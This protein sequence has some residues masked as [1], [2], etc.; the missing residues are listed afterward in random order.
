MTLILIQPALP[1]YRVNFFRRL[2]AHYGEDMRVHYSPIDMGALTASRARDLWEHPIGPIR[3]PIRGLEW[4]VGALSVPITRGDTVVVSGA[5]RTLS[6][7][8]LLAR[9]RMIGAH[10]IWWGQYW[11]ATTQPHRLYLRMKLSRLAD[12]LLFYT[13]AEVARYH[14]DGWVHPGPVGA[15]NNGIDLTEVRRLRRPYNPSVRGQ[16]LLFVGRLTAKAQL[17]LAINALAEPTLNSTYLHV[18]GEGAEEHVL[19]AQA[20]VLGVANRIIWYGGT[21]NEALI[22]EVANRCAAFVYPGQVGL[23]LIH[24]MGYGLPCIVHDQPTRHMP[25]IAA[26]ENGATGLTFVE[27]DVAALARSVRQL[28]D[29]KEA[30]V[31]MSAGCRA[32]TEADYT[33]ETMTARFL[34]FA[35]RLTGT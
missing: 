3:S 21:T 19:R 14:A 32:V 29:A 10:T 27:G 18:I 33:T 12:A 11:S 2:A 6:T 35:N 9:A 5:P 1:S 15:L 30:A 7:L 20:A 28:L 23:S 13:D 17:D 4:Q 22:A 16:N 8:L 24:A 34:S 25:E 31:E 26:F